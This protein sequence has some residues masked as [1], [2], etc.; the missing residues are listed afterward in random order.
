MPRKWKDLKSK[1]DIVFMRRLTESFQSEP[2]LNEL[3]CLY[4]GLDA[5]DVST[6]DSK[7]F[8]G[9]FFEWGYH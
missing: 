9:G 3:I 7:T 6:F 4:L 1:Y 8:A 2:D 5:Y